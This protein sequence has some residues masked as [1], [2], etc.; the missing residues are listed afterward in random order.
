MLEGRDVDE[1]V[2][3][4]IEPEVLTRTRS[5]LA[6]LLPAH[7]EQ[8]KQHLF[9][10]LDFYD[11]EMSAGSPSRLRVVYEGGTDL[12]QPPTEPTPPIGPLTGYATMPPE[13]PGF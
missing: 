2:G 9:Q 12:N 6:T 1:N 10:V 4:P 3:E 5:L 13:P 7:R 8:L 11:A